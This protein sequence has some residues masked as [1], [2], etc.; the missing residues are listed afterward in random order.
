M[1]LGTI[2]WIAD[3]LTIVSTH[4]PVR[5]R[6]RSARPCRRWRSSRCPR[7]CSP[8][9]RSLLRSRPSQRPCQNDTWFSTIYRFG[10][11]P[12]FL[13]SGTFFPMTQL[14]A[15]LRPLAYATPLYHGVTLCREFVLGQVDWAHVPVHAGYLIVLVVGRLP[16]RT[17]HVQAEAHHVNAGHH[18]SG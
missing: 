14:P 15:W 7:R 16:R 13:F 1:L 9:S 3:R 17:Q 2:T 12:L 6:R 11:V 10:V 5:D 18:I 4:L 8:V